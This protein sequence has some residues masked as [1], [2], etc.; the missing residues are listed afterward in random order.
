MQA[1][2]EEDVATME[3][4]ASEPDLRALGLGE[5]EVSHL[6]DTFRATDGESAKVAKRLMTARLGMLTFGIWQSRDQFG[7]SGPEESL[8]NE[9][10]LRYLA[11]FEA[12]KAAAVD[13][14]TEQFEQWVAHQE[15]REIGDQLFANQAYVDPFG[16]V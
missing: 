5:T 10:D 7:F 11:S 3:R 1:V 14:Y 13:F 2:F 6:C 9:A 4:I 12:V 15:L 16:E 8:R